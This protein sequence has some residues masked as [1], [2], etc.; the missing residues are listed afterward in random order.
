MKCNCLLLSDK[1][2]FGI[3]KK[4]SPEMGKIIQI[5]GIFEG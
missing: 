5:S 4:F 1:I 3:Q 2:D